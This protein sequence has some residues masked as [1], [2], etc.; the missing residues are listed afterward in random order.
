MFPP[1]GM[2][3]SYLPIFSHSSSIN[4]SLKPALKNHSAVPGMFLHHTQNPLN[5]A[6]SFALQLQKSFELTWKTHLA[7]RTED[8]GV[9]W[10]K[11]MCCLVHTG[12]GY[13]ILILCERICNSVNRRQWMAMQNHSCLETCK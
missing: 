7:N 2:P 3:G 1:C 6:C 5:T 9:L 4:S 11:T 10:W 8:V 12:S 13:L